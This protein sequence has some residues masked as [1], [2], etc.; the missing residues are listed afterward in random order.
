MNPSI[1]VG[2]TIDTENNCGC[3]PWSEDAQRNYSW[4]IKDTV[5]DI[6]VVTP[7]SISLYVCVEK[8]GDDLS[9]SNFLRTTKCERRMTLE[10]RIST[11]EA[12]YK[13]RWDD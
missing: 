5:T 11:D 3:V 12:C 1:C 2:S 6:V 7:G 10:L 9:V 4:K 8:A 13:V